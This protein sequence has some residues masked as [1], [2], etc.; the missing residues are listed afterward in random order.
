MQFIIGMYWWAEPVELLTEMMRIRDWRPLE[1]PLAPVCF[2]DGPVVAAVEF[3]KVEV[4][5]WASA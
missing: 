1:L 5:P 4:L 2:E 3:S